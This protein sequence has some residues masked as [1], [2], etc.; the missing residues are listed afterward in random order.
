MSYPHYDLV[1]QAHSELVA[2]GQIRRR[3]DQEEVEQD[4]GLLTRRA[5]YYAN[6]QRDSQHGILTK[7][8]GNN[9]L[10]Y[11]VDIIVH[12][13]GTF[14]DVAT[15]SGGLAQPVNGGPAGPDPELAARWAQP[16]ADLA[17][18]D[19]DGPGPAP[20]P[21]DED[22]DLDDIL[23][24]LERMQETQAR[25]TAM[26]IARDD[27]NTQRIMDELH[28]IVEEFEATAKKVLAV[29]LAQQ[30]P[31]DPPGTGEGGPPPDLLLL[32]LKAYLENRPER[33]GPA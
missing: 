7:T 15:D 26:I 17:G 27:L 29:W 33:G 4:K 23:A 14:W 28:R 13:D 25:D 18:L 8:Y 22:D 2:E 9:S 30:R 20:G 21:D 16:T 12:R 11:S 5:A 32:I 1:Q 10:G 6:A 24:E 31:D 19:D 3:T